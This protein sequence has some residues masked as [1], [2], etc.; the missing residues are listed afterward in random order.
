MSTTINDYAAH[1][2]K[3]K[4]FKPEDWA[5]ADY[6]EL[7][8]GQDCERARTRAADLFH[9]MTARLLALETMAEVYGGEPEDWAYLLPN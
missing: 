6:A 3:G 5:P 9:H 1:V 8:Y 7:A 2:A 4:N